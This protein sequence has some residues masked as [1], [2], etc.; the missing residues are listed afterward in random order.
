VKFAFY[1]STRSTNMAEPER[2][3]EGEIGGV[4]GSDIDAGRCLAGA[5]EP[6]F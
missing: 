3:I 1:L 2:V 5:S 6:K 4:Q